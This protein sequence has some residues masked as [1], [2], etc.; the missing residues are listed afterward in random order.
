[1]EPLDDF[2][3]RRAGPL[4]CVNCVASLHRRVCFN[5]IEHRDPSLPWADCLSCNRDCPSLLPARQQGLVNPEP[6]LT[7][8]LRIAAEYLI[9]RIS[10]RMSR[11]YQSPIAETALRLGPNR[12]ACPKTAHPL[13]KAGSQA[14][15]VEWFAD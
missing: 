6:Y 15:A 9:S 5:Q 10:E 3:K 7:D 14:A 12:N 2:G 13:P 11:S 1:M 4:T 8:S